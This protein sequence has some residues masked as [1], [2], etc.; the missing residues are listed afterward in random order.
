MSSLSPLGLG[1]R[2]LRRAG[3]VVGTAAHVVGL[4]F[5]EYH[6]DIPDFE[7]FFSRKRKI[8]CDGR[9]V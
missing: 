9:P 2:R 8:A 5:S 6:F 4:G 1:W 7:I 3:R